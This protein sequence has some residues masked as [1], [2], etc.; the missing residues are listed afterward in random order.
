MKPAA[1]NPHEIPNDTRVFE[2]ELDPAR[3]V[4]GLLDSSRASANLPVMSSP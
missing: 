4:Q 1:L 2:S 3:S